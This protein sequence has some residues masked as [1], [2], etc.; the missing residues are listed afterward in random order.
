MVKGL[1][2]QEHIELITCMQNP[3][4]FEATLLN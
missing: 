2:Y 4:I 1:T 3:K